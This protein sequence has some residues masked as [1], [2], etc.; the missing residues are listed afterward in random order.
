MTEFWSV[1]VYVCERER[2]RERERDP[3]S[4]SFPCNK[5]LAILKWVF[6]LCSSCEAN[7]SHFDP[8]NYMYLV[9]RLCW[10]HWF[11]WTSLVAQTVKNTPAMRET[12]IR[13][14]G[15][16]DPLEKGK[17]THSSILA[18]RIPWTE[19]LAKTVCTFKAQDLCWQRTQCIQKWIN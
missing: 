1:C 16:E 19:E 8:L 5:T 12:W 4:G 18:W 6:S 9:I 15:W 17:A 10:F 13:S 11:Y 7:P 14:L 2:E 3:F